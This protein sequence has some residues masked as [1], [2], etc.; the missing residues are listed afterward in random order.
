MR[1]SRFETI[2][3][4]LT[5]LLILL[6]ALDF[7]YTMPE[8]V[9]SAI[10]VLTLILLVDLAI[11][12]Y[13]APSKV[14]FFKSNIIEIIALLPFLE[15]LRLLRIEGVAS[16]KIIRPALNMLSGFFKILGE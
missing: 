12:F 5:L 6:V 3:A 1:P 7:F 8:W 14:L 4:V 9:K 13:R 11:K 2:T 15:E 16:A 10:A